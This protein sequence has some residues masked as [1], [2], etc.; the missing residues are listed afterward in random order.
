MAEQAETHTLETHI[1]RLRAKLG[2]MNPPPGDLVT[3]DGS[4]R[5]LL[6]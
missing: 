3:E 5:L 2:A 6:A 4:Y 1:Y